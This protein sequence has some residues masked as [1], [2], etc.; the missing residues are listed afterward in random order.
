MARGLLGLRTQS[1]SGLHNSLNCLVVI[2]SASQTQFSFKYEG[3]TRAIAFRALHLLEPRL[4]LQAGYITLLRQ[5]GHLLY[6]SK[7]GLNS[8]TQYLLITFETRVVNNK[9]EID[10]ALTDATTVCAEL[11]RPNPKWIH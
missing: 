9:M 5:S 7:S 10:T 8:K 2:Y 3:A 6:D 1:Y 4:G 11:R